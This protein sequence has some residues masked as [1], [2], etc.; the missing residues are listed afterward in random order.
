MTEVAVWRWS[1]LQLDNQMEMNVVNVK[2]QGSG[3]VHLCGSA[4]TPVGWGVHFILYVSIASLELEG[5]FQ[6]IWSDFTEQES[7][8]QSLTATGPS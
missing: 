6:I 1:S 2:M 4:V 7:E 3:S 5:S 8:M